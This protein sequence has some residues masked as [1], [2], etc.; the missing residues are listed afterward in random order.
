MRRVLDSISEPEVLNFAEGIQEPWS[1]LVAVTLTDGETIVG[2]LGGSRGALYEG[3]T[4]A[5]NRP[6]LQ[7]WHFITNGNL[8]I[9]DRDLYCER[10]FNIPLADVAGVRSIY[11][12][13][14]LYRQ[15]R[16]SGCAKGTKAPSPQKQYMSEFPKD[17]RS[18]RAALRQHRSQALKRASARRHR[19]WQEQ[20]RQRLSASPTVGSTEDISLQ[21][22]VEASFENM[23]LDI[24]GRNLNAL[25]QSTALRTA[26][27]HHYDTNTF[28]F[29]I[30]YSLGS[31]LSYTG[32]FAPRPGERLYVDWE[33]VSQNRKDLN[34]A[35]FGFIVSLSLSWNTSQAA[36]AKQMAKK[37]LANISDVCTSRDLVLIRG[38]VAFLTLPGSAVEHAAVTSG[39]K[40]SADGGTWRASVICTR[41]IVQAP[42]HATPWVLAYW[43]DGS[44]EVPFEMLDTSVVPLDIFATVHS[45]KHTT[46]FGTADCFLKVRY[47][48][49]A[50][51]GQPS[52][53]GTFA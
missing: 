38:H 50:V 5:N 31:S 10:Q 43:K 11:V 15:L 8:I 12:R 40:M 49:A 35:G 53:A 42:D 23:E 17:E 24:I 22:G 16:D 9:S 21:G 41:T 34:G 25:I 2:H 48:Q 46:S 20:L 52:W 45:G 33:Y 1:T 3:Q 29:G 39:H 6:E 13:Q 30:A 27:R 26:Q 37:P 19:E 28:S 18:L 32:D 7:T 14:P 44:A 51:T 47:A 4:Y 36:A